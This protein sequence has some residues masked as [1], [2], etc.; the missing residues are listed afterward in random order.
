VL[1]SIGAARQPDLLVLVAETERDLRA[2]L[3]DRSFDAAV[4]AAQSL[5]REESIALARETLVP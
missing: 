1:R 3:G 2:A 4:A 5:S